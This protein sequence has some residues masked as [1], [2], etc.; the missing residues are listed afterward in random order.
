MEIRRMKKENQRI[1][2]DDTWI[3]SFSYIFRN[4]LGI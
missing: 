1:K 2:S 3:K 4:E